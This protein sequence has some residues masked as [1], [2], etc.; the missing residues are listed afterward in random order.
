MSNL[1]NLLNGLNITT[2]KDLIAP[3]KAKCLEV[4]ESESLIMNPNNK[5]ELIK[6]GYFTISNENGNIH[7]KVSNKN[8]VIQISEIVDLVNQIS[9][10]NDLDL[11]FEDAEIDYYKDESVVELKIPLGISQF[12]T[13]NGFNDV[14]EVFL[15]VKTGFGGVS[16]SEAGIYTHRFVCSNGM[17]VRKGLSYFKCKHTERM[18]EKLKVF[19]TKALPLLN[20]SVKDFT[21]MAV[22]MDS[23]EITKEDIEA[24]RQNFFNY[25][26]D[27]EISTKKATMIKEFDKGLDIEMLRTGA[28]VWTLLQGATHYTNHNHYKA[29]K[30]FI[31]VGAGATLNENAEKF[32]LS[33]V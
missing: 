15:F 10:E 25:K 1:N 22:R 14:T 3:L 2:S 11:N 8:S 20:T 21:K 26:K 13:N 31:K 27:D 19:F 32:C 9:I 12:K 28:T 30:D 16:C 33:L 24:F 7:G 5:G 29:S 17:E 18:N 6:D 23:K 4:F